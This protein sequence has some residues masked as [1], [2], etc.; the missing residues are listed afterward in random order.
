[1][2][3]RPLIA[4]MGTNA[5]P[6]SPGWILLT[7]SAAPQFS[8]DYCYEHQGMNGFHRRDHLVQHLQD[9]H[10]INALDKLVNDGTVAPL[11]A[12]TSLAANSVLCEQNAFQQGQPHLFPCTLPGYFNAGLNG[13]FPKVDLNDHQMMMGFR[14]FQDQG[15]QQPQAPVAVQQHQ[16]MDFEL[17]LDF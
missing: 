15:A 6:A 2:L 1:M 11:S 10:R 14:G 16:D 8:C 7:G 3:E 9:F 13:Y 17:D 4:L 5:G 12:A